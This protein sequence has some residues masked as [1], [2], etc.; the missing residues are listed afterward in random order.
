MIT[1][2][3][4]ALVLAIDA[5]LL[6]LDEPTLGLEFVQLPSTLAAGPTLFSFD[7]RGTKRHELSIMLLKPGLTAV[8]ALKGYSGRASAHRARHDWQLSGAVTSAG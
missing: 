3:H 2:L 6:V 1:Q 7:N 8:C 4:L 5:R